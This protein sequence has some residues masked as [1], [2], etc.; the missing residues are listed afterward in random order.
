MSQRF[1]RGMTLME[2]LVAMVIGSLVIAL[3]VRGLG[4]SLN[5]YNRV[6]NI[7]STMDVRFRQARWWTQSIGSLV[8]CTDPGHCV[9]G[10]DREFTGFSFAPIMNDA[11]KRTSIQWLLTQDASGSL[12]TY[13]EGADGDS[14][15][16]DMMG[17]LP[18]DA[19]FA[20]LHADGR[21]TS[22]WNDDGQNRRL[23][24]AVRIQDGSG[25]VWLY[26]TTEQRPYGRD[27][28]RDFLGLQ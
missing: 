3:V 14:K 22:D 13:T 26:G 2:L 1:E 20:Y 7:T 23:P 11:G 17:K 15:P 12:L 6:A 25:A 9:K 4:L 19:S 5:L 21:W 28:Y 18:S 27:D 24:V 10:S 8:P 16:L